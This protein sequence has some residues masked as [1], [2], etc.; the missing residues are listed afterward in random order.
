MTDKNYNGWTNYE[1]WLVNM[2]LGNDEAS[3]FIARDIVKN[4]TEREA[5]EALKECLTGEGFPLKSPSLYSDMLTAAF[6][7]V[8]WIEIV[9]H[10][11]ED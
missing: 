6:S 2:W 9:K 1:T 4:G 10:Y 11:R 8:N 3:D 7:E 5:A